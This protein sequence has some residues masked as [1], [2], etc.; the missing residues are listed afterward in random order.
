MC[1]NSVAHWPRCWRATPLWAIWREDRDGGPAASGNRRDLPASRLLAKIVTTL[2][3]LS[4][5]EQCSGSGL[6]GMSASTTPTAF[7]F[8]HCPSG[9]R[10]R[11]D[12]CR[13]CIRCGG[14]MTGRSRAFTTSWQ[15]PNSPQPLHRPRI[16]IGGGRAQDAAA[17]GSV[18][19][20]RA[21]CSSIR[22]A[23]RRR[24]STNSTSCASTATT[25]ERTSSAS[26]RPCCGPV[27][28]LP[29]RP[30]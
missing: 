24:S 29:P 25:P 27:I 18:R 2:D 8:R 14:R 10:A 26:V 4:G 20:T 22:A 15:K 6:H 16:M 30:S 3:V 23:I 12:A 21:T 11:G 5:E 13:S 28:R 19:R 1:L 9:S 7:L 17:R